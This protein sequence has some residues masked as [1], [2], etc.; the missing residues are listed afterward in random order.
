V[1]LQYCYG[2]Q[3]T[4]L[5]YQQHMTAGGYYLCAKCQYA[6]T[7]LIWWQRLGLGLLI[8]LAVLA[9]IAFCAANVP[10]QG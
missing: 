2:C 9:A 1:K 6:P 7:P 4:L 8:V 3:A 10:L 5:P